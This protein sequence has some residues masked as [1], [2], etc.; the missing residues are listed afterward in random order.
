MLGKLAPC[1]GGPPIPLLK[2]KLLVGRQSSCDIPLSYPTVSARHCEL[3]LL[4]G[5]WFVRDLGSSNG[6]RVNGTPCTT[7]WLLPNDMLG[8]S[9]HRYTVL[10]TPPAD[11][12]PP[13]RVVAS[14]GIKSP[15][16][17]DV[18]SASPEVKRPADQQVW[19]PAPSG[20]SLGKLVPC[21]GGRPIPLL[22]PKLVVGRHPSCDIVLHFASVSARHCELEWSNGCWSVRD[23]G[24]RNGTRVDG[25]RCESERLAPG[26]ILWIGGLCFEI[27]YT[28]E[29]AE[30]PPARERRL[31]AQGLLEKAGLLDGGPQATGRRLAGDE[32]DPAHERK[33]LDDVGEV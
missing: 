32:N 9:V 7:E 26:S 3:E 2:P 14:A 24:S 21:G 5:Y 18:K 20:P 17:L 29:G 11:R 23:L 8:V 25:I 33:S 19:A 13:P 12:L 6:I 15:R 28:A 10:Y 31:F 22:R 30:S 4:H 27:V 16:G 1:G